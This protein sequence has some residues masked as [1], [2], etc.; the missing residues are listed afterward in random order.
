MKQIPS[1]NFFKGHK[2]YKRIAVVMHVSTSTIESMDSWFSTPKS[3][4]SAHYGVSKIG[5]VHQYVSEDNSSWAEG[6]VKKPT[7]KLIRKGINPNYYTISIEFE[8]NK[9][10]V[11]TKEMKDAGRKLIKAICTRHN[12]PVDRQHIISHHEI[13]YAK[14]IIKDKVDEM[15]SSLQSK[16]KTAYE[17]LVD[18]AKTLP[19]AQAKIVMLVANI[20]RAFTK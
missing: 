7:W 16:N 8:G 4:V 19:K 9:D 12:I 6:V 20:V 2:G 15:V 3:Q 5:K 1:P 18:I 13:D 10:D 14:P 17:M 11:W